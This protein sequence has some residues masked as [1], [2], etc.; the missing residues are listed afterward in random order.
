MSVCA[1]DIAERVLGFSAAE[2]VGHDS[3]ALQQK[4]QEAVDK[5]KASGC[6]RSRYHG[7]C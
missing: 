2:A 3:A 4:F 6:V 7:N 1:G 5:K